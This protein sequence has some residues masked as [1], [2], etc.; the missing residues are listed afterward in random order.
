MKQI[1]DSLT[2]LILKQ[3]PNEFYFLDFMFIPYL[4]IG[5]YIQEYK[6]FPI[7]NNEKECC[8][9]FLVFNVINN[10]ILH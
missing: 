9:D 6:E 7:K 1:L 2:F 3:H 8:F 5:I 10:N 4:Y